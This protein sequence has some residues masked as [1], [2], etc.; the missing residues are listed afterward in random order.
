M[1]ETISV[2]LA[3]QA[4]TFDKDA[5]RRLKEYLDAIRR[6]LPAGDPEILNDVEA[7]LAEIFRSRISSPMMVVT[8]QMVQ[9]AM[10]QMGDPSEFGELP[11]GEKRDEASVD[12]ESASCVS[13]RH[14]YRSRTNRSIA[15]VCGG[16]AEFFGI[17]STILRLIDAAPGTGRRFVDLGLYPVVDRRTQRSQT[18]RR[19]FPVGRIRDSPETARGK[20]CVFPIC[21][22][23]PELK[24]EIRNSMYKQR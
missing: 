15:G 14:L 19:E 5:Y 24:H 3:S 9:G 2:N 6:R 12:A 20:G 11:T 21:G 17:D 18:A 7:R 13:S 1:K 8:L 16:I 4:F 22:P 10:A 23:D